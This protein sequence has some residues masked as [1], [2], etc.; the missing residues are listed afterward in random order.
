MD[1][2][3]WNLHDF[4]LIWHREKPNLYWPCFEYEPYCTIDFIFCLKLKTVITFFRNVFQVLK[5]KFFVS[6][7]ET[8][9][10]K[11]HRNLKHPSTNFIKSKQAPRSYNF[12]SHTVITH[13]QYLTQ[14]LVP[15][16]VEKITFSIRYSGCS[17]FR[18]EC[19]NLS[20]EDWK[21]GHLKFYLSWDLKL[22]RWVSKN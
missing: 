16:C 1:F 15:F 18:T 12:N 22:E 3:F 7:F 20:S 21:N 8:S 6:L 14:I 19:T 13:F 5:M 10:M 2:T 4:G 17:N 11:W 9:K